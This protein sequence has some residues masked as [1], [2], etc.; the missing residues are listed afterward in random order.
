[1]LRRAVVL[2]SAV[3][4][5]LLMASGPARADVLIGTEGPDWLV[6]TVDDDRISGLGSGDYIQDAP[7]DY[8]PSGNDSVSGGGGDDSVHGERGNDSVSGGPGDEDVSGG[9]GSDVVSGDD[10]DDHVDEGPPF[11]A[12]HDRVYGGAGNDVVDTYNNPAVADLSSCGLGNDIAYADEKDIVANDC[13]K[14]VRGPEPTSDDLIA[15][16]RPPGP[17]YPV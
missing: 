8:G 13:E 17:G 15:F 14:I 12:S 6:G 3:A 2:F 10:G 5:T 9:L 16:A 7:T 1:C 4:A 11:D